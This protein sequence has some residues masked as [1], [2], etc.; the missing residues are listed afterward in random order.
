M[1]KTGYYDYR[2]VFLNVN[3][4]NHTPDG[5]HIHHKDFNH[6]NN[7]LDNLILVTV[8]EHRKIH[9]QRK[10]ELN[11]S[12]G[13]RPELIDWNKVY[14]EYLNGKSSRVLANELGYSKH[15]VDKMLKLRGF[16]LRTRSDANKL[17]WKNRSK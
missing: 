9:E 15:T 8:E 14:I 17:D 5:F 1:K 4:L 13:I 10:R 16:K 6:F 3:G 12:K 2:K 7:D 11:N